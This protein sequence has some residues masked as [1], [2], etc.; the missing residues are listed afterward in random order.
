MDLSFTAK[1][2]GHMASAKGEILAILEVKPRE[3]EHEPR[4]IYQ[5]AAEMVA[6]IASDKRIRRYYDLLDY[7]SDNVD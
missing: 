2:D 6:W 1:T 3:R 5:E 4:V 7:V